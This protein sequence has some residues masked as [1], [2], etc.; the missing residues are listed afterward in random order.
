VKYNKTLVNKE[1]DMPIQSY[2]DLLVWQKA[3]DLVVVCYQLTE[4]LPPSENFG[5]SSR[6]KNFASN[7]PSYIADGEGRKTNSEYFSRLSLAHGSLMSLETQL[8][9]VDRLKFLPI[10]E[11][12][13][14]LSLSSEVGK[15]LNGLMNKVGGG[16][17]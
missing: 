11:I 10:E 5:L 9:I 4:K 3:M 7:V 6:I 8:L 15:M 17:R 1:T 2:R 14:A 12:E 16:I 13:P